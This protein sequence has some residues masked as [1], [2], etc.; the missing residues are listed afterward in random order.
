MAI[1]L[2]VHLIAIFYLN[3]I[4]IIIDLFIYLELLRSDRGTGKRREES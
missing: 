2:L 1:A 3:T 4:I